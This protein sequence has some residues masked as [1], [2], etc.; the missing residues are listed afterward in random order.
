MSD[1]QI[2]KFN[3]FLKYYQDSVDLSRAMTEHFLH[4]SENDRA[5]FAVAMIMHICAARA[6]SA[7]KQASTKNGGEV[8]ND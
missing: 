8:S 2:K 4:L 6:V 1:L 7:Q 5:N 3:D